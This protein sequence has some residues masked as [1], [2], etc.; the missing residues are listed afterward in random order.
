FFKVDIEWSISAC[1]RFYELSIKFESKLQFYRF[2]KNQFL[3]NRY[4]TESYRL[5]HKSMF[6]ALRSY[7][8]SS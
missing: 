3:N 8:G 2:I 7:I 5:G 4:I 1:F 6:Y